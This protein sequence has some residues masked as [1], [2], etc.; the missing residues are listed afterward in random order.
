MHGSS[1]IPVAQSVDRCYDPAWYC[2]IDCWRRS[3]MKFFVA[4]AG[5]D[6]LQY[7]AYGKLGHEPRLPILFGDFSLSRPGAAAEKAKRKNR[8]LPQAASG[9]G[10]PDKM[11]LTL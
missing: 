2:L 8:S 9:C 10:R 11:A 4:L 6:W 3:F 5:S 7:G 1:L